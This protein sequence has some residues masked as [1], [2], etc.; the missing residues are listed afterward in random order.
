MHLLTFPCRALKGDFTRTGV[1][2]K[3]GAVDDGINS[4]QRYYLN[5]FIDADRQEGMDLLV[6]SAE[7]NYHPSDHD[8]VSRVILLQ[9]LARD[10]R[11]GYD[12]SHVRIKKKTGEWQEEHE[13]P[14]LN[15]LPGDLRHHMKAEALQ[16]RSP[17]SSAANE[18]ELHNA[19]K[20]SDFLMKVAC[21]SLAP[22]RSNAS[23]VGIEVL[24]SIDN[25]VTSDKPWWAGESNDQRL[26]N[27]EALFASPQKAGLALIVLLVRAPIFTTAVL[28]ALIGIL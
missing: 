27:S 19:T 23:S 21:S 9:E 3:R 26:D 4:V 20:S 16:S 22:Y 25:R 15:W 12:K 2:T 1:R 6:G 24:R 17:L 28:A 7:F 8:D 10:K 18:E 13:S 5:N 11:R 14:K